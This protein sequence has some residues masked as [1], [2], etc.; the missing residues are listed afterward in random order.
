MLRLRP[1]DTGSAL[2]FGASLDCGFNS[3]LEDRK[4]G[5]SAS[6]DKAKRAF[7]AE[8]KT[9]N[10][11][12]IKY[13]KADAD[14]S[15]IP[16]TASLPAG[17]DTPEP[18]V[19]FCLL[20]K[21]HALIE[22]YAAQVLP[23]IQ[24]VYEIQKEISLTNELGDTFTGII[25]LIAKID[26]KI[27]IIDN[28]SSSIRYAQD[29]VSGS[30]QL[31]SYYEAMKDEYDLAGA[32]YIVVPKKLRKVKEPRVQIEFIFGQI[33]ENLIAKTFEDYETVLHGVKTGQF[34]CTRN[35]AAGCCS[36]PW[37][38]PYEN[39]CNSNGEDMTGLKI[40]EKRK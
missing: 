15:A 36:M 21:G 18:L 35:E 4:A 23:R 7:T 22:E 9:I 1:V 19:W 6:I 8:F 12:E 30:E 27:W 32:C 20:Y 3:L 31:A 10:P 2:I 28:K 5:R 25:D 14:L 24:E 11:N 37:K 34:R 17:P 40:E 16:S 29:A 13:S 26:D 39:Y 33:S 38:C